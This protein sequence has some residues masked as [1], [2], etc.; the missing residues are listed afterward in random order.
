MIYEFLEVKSHKP[1]IAVVSGYN[2]E[3]YTLR[4]L[5]FEKAQCMTALGIDF[6]FKANHCRSGWV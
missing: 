4:S 1:I 5:A 3:I 2:Q 6:L